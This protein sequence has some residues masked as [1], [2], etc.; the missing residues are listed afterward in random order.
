MMRRG[1]ELLKE[2]KMRDYNWIITRFFLIPAII[3]GT[4]TAISADIIYVPADQPTIQAGLNAAGYGDTVLVAPGTY[5][6]NI[7]WPDVNGIKLFG[8]DRESTIID[9]NNQASVLRFDTANIVDTTTV[10][11]GFTL[12]NGNALP[13]WPESQGGGICL[14]Y[15]SPILEYLTIEGNTAHDF[16]GGI[17]IWG[18]AS[19]PI[20][21]YVVIAGNT[22]ISHGGVDCRAGASVFDH[23]TVSGND[24]GGMFFDTNGYARIENSIVAFNSDYGVRVQGNS[25]E[26]TTIAIGYSDINDAVQLIGYAYVDWLEGN[27]DT[28]P[29]FVDHDNGDFHLQAGSPCIDAGDPN[30]PYDPDGTITDMGAFYFDQTTGI[31]DGERLPITFTL[32]QNYPNPFNASTK[33][34]YTLPEGSLIIIDIYNILGQQVCTLFEGHQGAG[35]HSIFWQPQ[36]LSS[37]LYFARL[38]TGKQS[39]SVVMMLL[40]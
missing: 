29:L 4:A 22:A 10:V 13:P 6:E 8:S 19:N 38:K 32:H 40:E 35:T 15:A 21:R 17:Y 1:L 27:I 12:T 9:G 39:S 33:I 3:L 31:S 7:I 18:S 24:P 11:R 28:D 25:F 2:L 36:N 37:G 23:V 30:Y 20:I 34:G 26:Q 16:G 14:F 5:V